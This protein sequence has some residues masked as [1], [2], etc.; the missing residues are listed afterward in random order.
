VARIAPAYRR[1]HEE[2]VDLHRA[3]DSIDL[4][5]RNSRVFSRRL[6]SAINHAALSDEASDSL[7]T[8]LQEAADGVEMLAA[9][10]SDP[11]DGARERRLR[12]ARNEFADVATRL[13]P[14]SL[15]V[16]SI[17]GESL[18]MVFRPLIVDLLEAT[19]V[20]HDE[21]AGYLPKV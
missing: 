8:L 15:G 18:V 20:S 4:A 19:G 5:M 12:N 21:A 11:D 14:K 9:G 17:E 2:V 16:R 13:H 1:H 7:A 10:L 6:T 3:A